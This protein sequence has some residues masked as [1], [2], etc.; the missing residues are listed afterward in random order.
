[1]LRLGRRDLETALRAQGHADLET[2]D[3][4]CLE[5]NGDTTVVARATPAHNQN[6]P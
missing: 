6:L 4:V 5:R 2:V 3:S 1:M